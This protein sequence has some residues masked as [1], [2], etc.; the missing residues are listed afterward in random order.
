MVGNPDMLEVWC[1]PCLWPDRRAPRID[2]SRKSASSIA[3]PE[4]P[5]MSEALSLAL[6]RSV[7]PHLAQAWPTRIGN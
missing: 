2:Y 7:L 5:R 4:T 6:S 3:R 1:A